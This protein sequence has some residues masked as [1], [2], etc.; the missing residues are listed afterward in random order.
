M[1]YKINS[2]NRNFVSPQRMKIQLLETSTKNMK[3]VSLR[4]CHTQYLE[5]TWIRL[6]N[7]DVYN[8]GRD[9]LC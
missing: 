5:S 1:Y 8:P 2:L 6:F 7:I 3:D 9:L 4:H